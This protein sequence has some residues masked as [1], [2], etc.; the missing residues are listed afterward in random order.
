MGHALNDQKAVAISSS[1]AMYNM[2]T[3]TENQNKKDGTTMQKNFN[4]AGSSSSGSNKTEKKKKKVI[5]PKVKQ[6][7]D[8]Q[9]KKFKRTVKRDESNFS[10]SIQQTSNDYINLQNMGSGS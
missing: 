2:M 3:M 6:E 8:K 9:M 10:T 1:H 5:D 4:S 7:V